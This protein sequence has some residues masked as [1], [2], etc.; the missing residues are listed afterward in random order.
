LLSDSDDEGPSESFAVAVNLFSDDDD[1]YEGALVPV[2]AEASASGALVPVGAQ[3]SAAVPTKKRHLKCR[4]GSRHGI[5]FFSKSVRSRGIGPSP[6]N[7]Y[8][9]G[10]DPSPSDGYGG[11]PTL[12]SPEM[13]GACPPLPTCASGCGRCSCV[14]T[15]AA[16]AHAAAAAAV[17]PPPLWVWLW[18]LQL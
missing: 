15:D 9:P 1:D 12:P 16:A 6:H 10:W 3:A 18:E 17:G 8:A 13:G 5:P 2:G 14:C 7:I 4:N 11:L